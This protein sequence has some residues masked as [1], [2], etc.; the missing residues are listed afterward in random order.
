M[1]RLLALHLFVSAVKKYY[2]VA[3]GSYG[4]ICCDNQGAIYRAG[5]RRKRI[6]SSIP[7]A[8]LLRVL[9]DL[10]HRLGRAFRYKHVHGHQDEYA[11]WSQLSL[12]AQL[13]VRCDQLAKEAVSRNAFL[14]RDQQS[15]LLPR[16]AAAVFVG[17]IKQTSEVGDN[18]RFHA[19]SVEE[20]RFYTHKLG[21]TDEA[22]QA[23]DWPSLDA[24]LKSIPKMFHVWLCKQASDFSASGVQ[25]GRWFGRDCTA[26]PNCGTNPEHSRHLLF[27]PDQDWSRH[28]QQCISDLTDWLHKT[29]D[30]SL[31]H[32]TGLYL[33]GRGE[34]QFADIAHLPED[35][36]ELAYAQD[37]IGWR[38]MLE[39]KISKHFFTL[40]DEYLAGCN[41]LLMTETWIK[42]FISKLLHITHSQWIYRNISHHH[43]RYGALELKER[44]DLLREIDALAEMDP[45]LVPDESKFLLEID[46]SHLKGD[47]TEKQRY[48]VRGMKAAIKAGRRRAAS[49][50]LR[51]RISPADPLPMP[52]PP[53]P[54]QGDEPPSDDPVPMSPLR[55]GRPP[56]GSALE[57]ALC[58]RRPRPAGD[59]DGRPS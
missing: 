27:C 14:H 55:I 21:W 47:H 3:Q 42:A 43:A 19:G 6:A 9:R 51:H 32:F 22:F 4:K 17:G 35:L 7:N 11:L 44:R 29:S 57:I 36:R 48:W 53:S 54:H 16:E 15:Q 31:A 8:D 25:M 2:D 46:F 1:L 10:H 49:S 39:G 30:P 18:L 23:V 50:S 58:A 12:E 56:R 52:P 24:T 5:R 20:R 26:C 41:T 40:Q 34:V 59:G 13:N 45:A 33:R 37:S 38:N 28:L